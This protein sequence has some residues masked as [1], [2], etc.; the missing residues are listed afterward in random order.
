M[1]TSA[2]K[3]LESF[4]EASTEEMAAEFAKDI[5]PGTVVALYGDL[6]AG[7]TVFARG[8]ARGLGITETVS[9]PTFTLMQEYKVAGKPRLRW[10][11]HLDLYRIEDSKAALVFGVDEYLSGPD[12]VLLIEWAERIEDILPP[13]TMRVEISHAGGDKRKIKFT[14][15]AG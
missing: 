8:F 13:G 1:N 7:K 2:L 12:S 14:K 6:G 9:S 4:S 10:F 3:E 5:L 11:Y 15:I